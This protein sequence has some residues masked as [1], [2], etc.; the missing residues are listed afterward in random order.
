MILITNRFSYYISIFR[1]LT[2]LAKW[3]VPLGDSGILKFFLQVLS[4]HELQTDLKI[5]ILR[6]I[7]NSCADT[8][9]APLYGM[10]RID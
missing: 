5:Q 1:Q 6:L 4:T 10:L 7:G 9:K 8:G 2:V 3:R